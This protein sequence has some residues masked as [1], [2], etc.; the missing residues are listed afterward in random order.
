MLRRFILLIASAAALAAGSAAA[1]TQCAGLRR[2]VLR[3]AGGIGCALR[4]FR[5]RLGSWGRDE[6]VRRLRLRA[7]RRD[8]PADPRP[9][10]PGN[11]PRAGAEHEFRVLLADRKKKVTAL[12]RPSRSR[13]RTARDEQLALPAGPV[14][15]GTGLKLAGQTLTAPLTFLPGKGGPLTLTRALPRPDP[16]RRRRRKAPRRQHRRARAVPRRRRAVGDAFDL[17]G[18]GARRRRPWRR[19]RMRSRRGRS[20]RRTTR[21]PTRAA[22]CISA[23]SNESPAT[24]AA[25]TA[26]K[27]QV[28][29]FG[30]KVATTFFYSTSGG[31][32]ESSVDWT[33]TAAAVSRS[34]CPTRTTTSRRTT[35]GARCRSPRR[36]SARRS[37]CRGRSPT[38]RRSPNAAG[39]VGKLNLMTPL[40]PPRRSRRRRS[41]RRSACARRGSRSA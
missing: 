10:L 9:L 40:A 13:S 28:L 24:T 17:V 2:N 3:G 36:R 34:R 15:F 31:E 27:G 16:G 26:T 38:Q 21:T 12:L 33:G 14:T 20:A 4:L 11:D 35:T 29:F 25:V 30:G 23:L 18:A 22:R 39:R 5:S 7:A 8:L 32:T 41:A 19:A 1:A 6:P 37:K